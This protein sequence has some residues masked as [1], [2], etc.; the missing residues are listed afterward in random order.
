VVGWIVARLARLRFPTL[1]CITAL[2]FV[3]DLVVPDVIPLA[4]EIL[5]GLVAALLGSLKRR[6]EAPGGRDSSQRIG[7]RGSGL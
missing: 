1:F 4:D 7:R 2:L 6:D 3:V 5:L